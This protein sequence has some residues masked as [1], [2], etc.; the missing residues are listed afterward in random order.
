MS[1][2]E[3]MTRRYHK[4]DYNCAHLVVEVF[5]RLRGPD[6]AQ[7]LRAYLCA[8]EERRSRRADLRKAVVLH[9][10]VTPCVVLMQRKRETHVGVWLN[11]RVLHI[12]EGRGVM[13]V[14]LEV[15][16]LGFSRVRFFTC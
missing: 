8:P 6:V 14:P 15:A 13:H 11:G 7:V 1:T 12:M 16:S 9:E 3:F 2:D 4:R 10:P 5:E